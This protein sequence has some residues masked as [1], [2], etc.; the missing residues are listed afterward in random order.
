[1]HVRSFL[2]TEMNQALFQR[3]PSARRRP[4]RWAPSWNDPIGMFMQGHE[5][6]VLNQ[7][8]SKPFLYGDV[9]V[10]CA[11]EDA[12][13]IMS[14]DIILAPV[15]MQ[16]TFDSETDAAILWCADDK[17]TTA[18]IRELQSM[19]CKAARDG[20][21][22]PE[23]QRTESIQ[24]TVVSAR[25]ER[26]AVIGGLLEDIQLNTL[27]LSPEEF[28]TPAGMV[29]L[30]Q[31]LLVAG[32][33]NLIVLDP[34]EEP[35]VRDWT[36]ALYQS[37]QLS[38]SPIAVGVL[39]RRSWPADPLPE[40]D[41]LESCITRLLVMARELQ[42]LKNVLLLHDRSLESALIRDGILPLLRPRNGLR[43][44]EFDL[45]QLA[46]QFYKKNWRP[47]FEQARIIAERARGIR[48]EFESYPSAEDDFWCKSRAVDHAVEVTDYLSMYNPE[49][50]IL[51]KN[52]LGQR[53]LF[54]KEA[55]QEDWDY[56]LKLRFPLIPLLG[57]SQE[58]A[59]ESL[60][61]A[62]CLDASYAISEEGG[63]FS[64]IKIDEGRTL[65]S[66]EELLS[67]LQM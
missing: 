15:A 39:P 8:C 6:I 9:F 31:K 47:D 2:S 11:E 59:P 38:R 37:L 26:R 64:I 1:M 58:N 65:P 66:I 48:R 4:R 14:P 49:L 25:D 28:S 33:I 62:S 35:A 16:S 45:S 46:L 54:E 24:V 13:T 43:V 19:L 67:G 5:Q 30:H 63:R 41:Y 51:E 57:I 29:A 61:K 18:F 21:F 60:R 55:P 53:R 7:S 36:T 12:H 20:C 34:D 17:D 27:F 50:I 32:A 52:A 3:F 42:D 44:L 22:I 23:T 56:F 40:K 10:N